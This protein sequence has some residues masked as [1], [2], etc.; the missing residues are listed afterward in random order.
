[1][2]PNLAILMKPQ[3]ATRVADAD[4]EMLLEEIRVFIAIERAGICERRSGCF[5]F[6]LL[7]GL[8]TRS[9]DVPGVMM[10]S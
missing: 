10:N 3:N 1:M 9:H 5:R 2:S 4:D 7:F 8:V 6:C